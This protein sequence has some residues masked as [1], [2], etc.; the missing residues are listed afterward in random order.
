MNKSP[1]LLLQYEDGQLNEQEII[2]FF[3]GIIDNGQVWLLEGRYG[4]MAKYLIDT[5]RCKDKAAN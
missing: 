2:G 5:G 1:D 4:R 3:Q